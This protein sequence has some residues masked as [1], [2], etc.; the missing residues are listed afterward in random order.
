MR[1]SRLPPVSLL[2]EEDEDDKQTSLPPR[3]KGK[4]PQLREAAVVTL[5]PRTK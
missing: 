5:K 1:K 3:K 4:Y 2:F